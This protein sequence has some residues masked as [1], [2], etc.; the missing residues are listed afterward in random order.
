MYAA[1]VNYDFVV[2]SPP[3]PDYPAAPAPDNYAAEPFAADYEARRQGFLD[4]VRCNPAPPNLKAPYYELARVAAGDAPHEGVFH[5]ALDYVEARKDCADFVLHAV[6]RLLY[7]FPDRVDAALLDRARQT[8]RGFKHWPGEPG[9][10]SM[11]SWTEN[12][13]ILFSS[14]AYLAG[15][16][17]PDDVFVNSGETGREKMTA[18]GARIRRWLDLRFRTGF[19][20]WL[21][22]VYYDEDLT[23]LL[24]LVDFC[25]DDEIRRR[26]AIVVDLLLLD[27]ALNSYR[28][29]MGCT[30][31]RSY[32]AQ[33]KWLA[34]ED[35][36]DVQKLLFGR[37]RFS[38]G[39]S[40]SAACLALSE[41]YRMPRVLYEIAN[42]LDR[43]AMV[44]RQRHG[45]R[46]SE[47]ERWG[48]G[49]D[50]LEDGMVYL[51]LEAY[52]HPRTINLF[53][54]L[55]DA[56]DWWEND[57][58]APFKS[59]R[60]LLSGARRLGLLPLIAR[61]AERDITRNTREEVHT[62]TC[63]TPDYLLSSAQDYRPGYGG[64][65]QHVWQATLGPDAV[66]FT[67]HPA[68]REGPSPNYWTGSG[69]LPRVAQVENV[70]L[71]V[72][73]ID[74]RPGLYVTHRLLFTHAWL[75]RDQF[76]E[77]VEQG[78]WILARKGDGY[79]ALRSQQPYRWQDEPGED[80]G[81]EVI[82]PGKENVWIC[83]LG[84]RA[85]DGEF[86]DFVARIVAAG[87]SFGRLQVRYDSPSQGRLDFGWRGPL[88]RDGEEVPL[89][90]HPRYDNPYVHADFPAERV[91]VRLGEH[92][93]ELDWPAGARGAATARAT[94]TTPSAT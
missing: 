50:S 42:D 25:A 43:P 92:T 91:S 94:P 67:T 54:R 76:D 5:A 38:G 65:Q 66:C 22:N 36:A 11:C 89:H 2:R 35:V 49:F 69:S 84:R 59:R 31:G 9:L 27:V 74:T 32:E 8:V 30:H 20:E 61:L 70:V 60:G 72:Y 79:L 17:Y 80:R 73:K 10:D 41:R 56:F 12:H 68:R 51:S 71:A 3:P 53:A 14:A 90:G 13:Q 44:N 34:A 39:E 52:A 47:A 62:Y 19:S 57:F 78:G 81:R 82:A 7:Q 86:G 16:L 37:G 64:D 83:E 4:H 21:S 63:R 75:P 15:Q 87:V 88:R 18:H 45:I 33:K 28:G 24:S 85:V 55:L 1:S 93:L 58:F 77:V 40:M 26:A 29:V 48:L 23:A 46:L 6:L